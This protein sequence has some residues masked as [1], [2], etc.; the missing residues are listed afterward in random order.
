MKKETGPGAQGR[1]PEDDPHES[2]RTGYVQS[3]SR[4]LAIARETGDRQSE[5]LW[6]G[7]LGV[8]HQ[9]LGQ[10]DQA[11]DCFQGAMA[12]ARELGDGES[13]WAWR[14]NLGDT[15][16]AHPKKDFNNNFGVF[17]W[18]AASPFGYNGRYWYTKAS[19]TL[20]R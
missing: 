12:A 17:P 4:A 7:S 20:P 11:V 14:R 1:P 6:L 5:E 16:P 8:V 13:E 9:R 18:A 19:W 10:L 3:L 15:Y 2:G